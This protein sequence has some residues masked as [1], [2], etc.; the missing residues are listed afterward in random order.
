[1]IG[2]AIG[3]LLALA[4]SKLLRG[5]LYG[6]AGIDAS[7]WLVTAGGLV[8]ALVLASVP[9]ARRAALADPMNALRGDPAR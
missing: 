5:M 9:P 1:M 7:A 2:Q 8:L 4:S 6:V 3:L